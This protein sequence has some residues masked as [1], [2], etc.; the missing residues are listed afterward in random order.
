MATRS[1]YPLFS[2][3]LGQ[4][5]QTAIISADAVNDMCRPLIIK[6][7]SL[8][9]SSGDCQPFV[10]LGSH[11]SR[12]NIKN[13]EKQSSSNNNRTIANSGID[14]SAAAR[15]MVRTYDMKLCLF[16]QMHLSC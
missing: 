10:L 16:I 1:V 11:S 12:Q 9:S 2:Y 3:K 5:L 15:H 14:G 7:F 13:S 6:R 8:V 4:T